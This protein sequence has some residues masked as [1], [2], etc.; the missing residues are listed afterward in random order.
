MTEEK[1]NTKQTEK[2]ML[3]RLERRRRQLQLELFLSENGKK[4]LEDQLLNSILKKKLGL[5]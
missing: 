2:E 3:S 4:S 5:E 1:E